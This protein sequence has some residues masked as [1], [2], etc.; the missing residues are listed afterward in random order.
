MRL[1]ITVEGDHDDIDFIRTKA[2]AMVEEYVEEIKEE[3]RFDNKV[4]VGWEFED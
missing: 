4:E 2:V 1:V 3:G